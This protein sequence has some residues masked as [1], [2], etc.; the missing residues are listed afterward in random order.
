VEAL[1]RREGTRVGRVKRRVHTGAPCKGWCRHAHRARTHSP[2]PFRNGHLMPEKGCAVDTSRMKTPPQNES[3]VSWPSRKRP[4]L[5]RPSFR[6]R[7][8]GEDGAQARSQASG[9]T[10]K[11][12]NRASPGYRH[13]LPP[14]NSL[15]AREPFKLSAPILTLPRCVSMYSTLSATASMSGTSSR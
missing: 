3:T 15:T 10:C 7:T 9:R 11:S 1:G 13:R 4:C 5:P 8:C 2:G 12:R 14:R 6:R